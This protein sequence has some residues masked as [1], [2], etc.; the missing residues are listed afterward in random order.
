MPSPPARQG[1]I[2]ALCYL[3]ALLFATI[4]V[5]SAAKLYLASTPLP[6]GELARDLAA[7]AT[8]AGLAALLL[9]PLPGRHATKGAAL[10]FV[11]LL[12]G[13]YPALA[14]AV[15]V[16]PST[17]PDALLGA[18]FLL[19]L[20]GLLLALSRLAPS[21]LP[22]SHGIIWLLAAAVAAYYV[23]SVGTRLV[24]AERVP[25]RSALGGPPVELP[26]SADAPDII[27]IVFDGLGRLD[28]LQRVYGLDGEEIHRRLTAQGLHIVD[29]AVANYAQTYLAMA[30]T[31]SMEY[32]DEAIPLATS[33]NDRT[34][35][36]T[37]ID[38]STVIRALKR[39]G[40]RFTLLSSGYEAFVSHPLADDGIEGPTVMEQFEAY[41]LPRTM[42]RALPI[43]GLTFVPHRNRTREI[44]EALRAYRPG[45]RPRFV[46]AHLLLPH[47]PFVF[48]AGGQC[49]DAAWHL[50]A[51]R[52]LRLPGH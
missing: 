12:S 11:V 21:V 20:L 44:V 6:A 47:P 49:G 3:P 24:R 52:R 8:V 9:V 50:R 48:D 27:H 34:L 41:A 35:T 19:G 40:Y 31:L 4:P 25:D 45:G 33:P 22:Q 51:C 29:G 38:Q 18:A 32:L 23:Y 46:L 37:I 39:R 16:G 43:R 14:D 42:F 28:L 26:A 13:A 10:S 15:G 17:W 30:A 1:P 7:A 36:E 5:V 2:P